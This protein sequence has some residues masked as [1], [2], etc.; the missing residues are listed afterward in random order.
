M[1]LKKRKKKKIQ[2]VVSCMGEGRRASKGE[3]KWFDF[4]IRNLNMRY[5]PQYPCNKTTPTRH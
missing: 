2:W 5:Q 3:Y 1:Y 4:T